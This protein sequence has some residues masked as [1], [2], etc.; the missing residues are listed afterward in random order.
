MRHSLVGLD[1]PASLS[2][3]RALRNQDTSDP[4]HFGPKNVSGHFR[5]G[6]QNVSGKLVPGSEMFWDTWEL[7][8]VDDTTM[9]ND[10]IKTNY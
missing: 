1:V 8:S 10:L 7:L 5:S 2:G 6:D 4:R 9:H 3:N